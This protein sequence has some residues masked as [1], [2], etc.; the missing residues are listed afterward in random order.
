MRE[1]APMLR[2]DLANLAG[3]RR[4]AAP[5]AAALVF[6]TWTNG[7]EMSMVM[8]SMGM[9]IL[10]LNPFTTDDRYRMALLYGGLPVTRR[11]VIASHYLIAVGTLVGLLALTPA[12]A[13]LSHEANGLDF[14]TELLGTWAS[15][16][17]TS[18]VVSVLLPLTVRFGLEAPAYMALGTLTLIALGTVLERGLGIPYDLTAPAAWLVANAVL[19]A[20]LVVTA[21]AAAWWV[22][23][24]ISARLYAVK[25][26]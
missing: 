19:A 11:S 13:W 20:V 16:L 18:L 17:L 14:A 25:D 1:L 3:W 23:Y 10:A 21:V 2:M 22:S 4:A 9:V 8:L 6:I 7:T 12:L 15:L 24:L 26:F 5:V